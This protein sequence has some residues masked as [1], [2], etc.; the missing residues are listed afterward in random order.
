MRKTIW[1]TPSTDQ[2]E[3]EGLGRRFVFVLKRA[4]LG[5][6]ERR[7]GGREEG[8]ITGVTFGGICPDEQQKPLHFFVTRHQGGGIRG[9]NKG[10]K[11]IEYHRKAGLSRSN[12]HE[13][14]RSLGRDER[15]KSCCNNF[16]SR[17]ILAYFFRVSERCSE[18]FRKNLEK[19]AL[20]QAR[21]GKRSRLEK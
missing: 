11:S 5:K 4:H 10:G 16:I 14:G 18:G 13:D 19:E 1:K 7:K 8:N 3:W 17:G 21:G 6:R 9:K 2:G 15:G 12:D 20:N